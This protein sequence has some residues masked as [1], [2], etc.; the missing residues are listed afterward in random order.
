MRFGPA[1]RAFLCCLV[2]GG[3]GLG[4]V[5]QKSQ[6]H[7]LGRQIKEKENTLAQLRRENKMRADNLAALCSPPALEA[8]IKKLNLGLVQP[9]VTQVVRLPEPPVVNTTTQAMQMALKAE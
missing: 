9:E 8:R 7:I 2:L 6:I 4:Y 3:S 1:C 5:W